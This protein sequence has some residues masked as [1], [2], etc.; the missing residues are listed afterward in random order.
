[1][2]KAATY[3]SC[4]CG[5][6][7]TTCC[8]LAD[9]LVSRKVLSATLT[10]MMAA[11]LASA[12][13]FETLSLPP[14]LINGQIARAHTQGLEIVGSHYFVTARLDSAIPKRAI[15]LRTE[16]HGMR[17]DVWD[18]TPT[19][20]PGIS[21]SLDHPGGLQSDGKRLWIPV[22]ESVR[23]GRS[24]IRVFA[25]ERLVP[26][27]AANSSLEFEVADHIGAVAVAPRQ[28]LVLGASWDTE[29]VYVWDLEGH[30]RRT[31]SGNEL[32]SRKLGAVS[33]L[34][35]HAGVTV[36]DWKF[37]GDQLYAS[38]LFQD[39]EGVAVPP[40]S[41]FL[42]FEHF[43]ES[44]FEVRAIR[45][46]RRDQTELAQEAMAISGGFVYYLPEDLGASNRVFRTSLEY[47][48]KMPVER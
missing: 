22:G 32:K 35:G 34:K 43:L 13:E 10:L 33:G 36:Q 30:L 31:L 7:S 26:D 3:F 47:L 39:P 17:W 21:A 19:N 15:L 40:K 1:V 27:L 8:R 37:V 45:L 6:N 44:G 14:L 42:V 5:I 18:L 46:P 2:K 48:L 20:G 25:L 11:P 41:R 38:G 9:I 24:L 4:P 12:A 16:A 23:H 29:T 28:Q